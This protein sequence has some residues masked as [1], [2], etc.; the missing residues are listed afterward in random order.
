MTDEETLRR[1]PA[2]AIVRYA[3][4]CARRALPLF[5]SHWDDVTSAQKEAVERAVQMAESGVA[6]ADGAATASKV[7]G[8]AE[9]ANQEQAARVAHA[10]AWAAD[11]AYALL[12]GSDAAAHAVC[13]ACEHARQAFRIADGA[14]GLDQMKQE[15]AV[16]EQLAE[17]RD[18]TGATRLGG[19]ELGAIWPDPP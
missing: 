9:S 11:A 5:D 16:L 17:S 12:A 4:R 13:A 1:L 7:A 14:G 2:A 6:T 19:D 18:W 3:A 15:F 8:E 10:A